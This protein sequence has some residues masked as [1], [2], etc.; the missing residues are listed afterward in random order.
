MFVI[1]LG[2][3]GLAAGYLIFGRVGGEYLSLREVFQPAE[4][5]LEDIS[6]TITGVQNAR[7]NIWISG[8]VGGALG[9]IVGALARRRYS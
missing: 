4:N 7:R 8:A 3:I 2:G 1:I 6:E 5:I 9:V